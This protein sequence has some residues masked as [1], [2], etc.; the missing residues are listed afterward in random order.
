MDAS[1]SP[2][3]F[4]HVLRMNKNVSARQA[5][6][7]YFEGLGK[8]ILRADKGISVRLHQCCRMTK[9]ESI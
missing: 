7:L 5:M 6:A 9:Q 1:E 8:D 2:R 4:G 3:P